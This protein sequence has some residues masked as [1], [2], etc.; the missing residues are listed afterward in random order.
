MTELIYALALLACPVGMG[1]M[2]W[3]MMR[4]KRTGGEPGTTAS[5]VAALRSE[6][7]RLRAGRDD[8]RSAGRAGSAG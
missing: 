2:M 6:V 1:T 3:L 4:G 5:D 8:R 7:A